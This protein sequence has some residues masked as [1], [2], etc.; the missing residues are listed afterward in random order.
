MVTREVQSK[1]VEQRRYRRYNVSFPCMVKPRR[2]RKTTI[3]TELTAQTVDISSGGMFLYAAAEWGVGTEIECELR[4]PVK[5][6]AGRLVGIRC[7]GKIARVVE[8]QQEGRIGFGATIDH[9]EF[10]HLR[11]AD[12]LD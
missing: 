7:R 11:R 9:Y 2:T 3:E 1:T 8:Q 6:F 5:A 10:L 12:K 4:L